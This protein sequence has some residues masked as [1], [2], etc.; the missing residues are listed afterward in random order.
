MPEP[1]EL[2]DEAALRRGT[3]LLHRQPGTLGLRSDLAQ[4]LRQVRHAPA[5]AAIFTA[6]IALG[7]GASLTIFMVIDHVFVQP[8]DVPDAS[9]LV[10][11]QRV[12][13]SAMLGVDTYSSD[14]WTREGYQ[15]MSS[16]STVTLAASDASDPLPVDF[17]GSTLQPRAMFITA[18]YLDLLGVTPA[19]GRA[20]LPSED[21]EGAPVTAI[22]GHAVWQTH[23][24]G[25]PA[26]LGRVIRVNGSP[27][28]VVGIAPR[29]FRGTTL[30]TR[31]PDLLLPF[32]ARAQLTPESVHLP[33]LRIVG[34]L[35]PGATI[36][37]ASAE[38]MTIVESGWPRT[39]PT[40]PPRARARP[41]RDALV[42]PDVQADLRWF[43]TLLTVAVGLTVAIGCTNLT[44]LLL[45]RVDT[46]RAEFALRSVLGATRG[47]LARQ[48]AVETAVL[49]F[50]GG[51][52]ALVV[53]RLIVHGLS[54]FALPG[55]VALS[56][57]GDG[58]VGRTL[59]VAAVLTL[60]VAS[61]VGLVPMLRATRHGLI[62]GVRELRDGAARR[63]THVLVGLQVA[64]CVVL[65]FGA[66]LFVRS[67]SAML[68]ADVGFDPRGLVSASIAMP[69]STTR[70]RGPLIDALVARLRE[71][72]DVVAVAVG[73][74]PLAQGSNMSTAIIE[75]DGVPVEIST[76]LEVAFPGPGYFAT[77][78][79]PIVAGRD[80][81]EDDAARVDGV[82][83]VNES[84]ARALWGA[85]DP[86]AR[87]IGYNQFA[88][89]SNDV[90]TVIGV[91]RDAMVKGIGDRRPVL[92]VLRSSR[93]GR[94]DF[95]ASTMSNALF[96]T[97][98]TRGEPAMLAKPLRRAAADLG[99]PVI[100]V[101]PI[102]TV[103]DELV[104]PQ[105]LG[106]ALLTGLGGVA[107]VVTL[108]GIYG[109]VSGGVSRR[110]RDA[111]IRLALGASRVG[112]AAS[113]MKPMLVVVMLG[114][115]LGA[116]AAW[117]SGR[118]VDRFLYGVDSSDPGTLAL[119]L[120][121]I[122]TIA[123]AAAA[124][125]TVR[126]FRIDPAEALRVDH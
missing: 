22:L 63:T 18:D 108:V 111:G 83:I 109:S 48:L 84:A 37:Q 47:R 46:R 55:G 11:L 40:D 90:Y 12:A 92:Y 112:V 106:R 20:F 72:P 98:R 58:R 35:A 7:L 23:F 16:A 100:S 66:G 91:V 104:K 26:V 67:L 56:T 81:S 61:T 119:V 120:L 93:P 45:A 14:T 73:P 24:G 49:A 1:Q 64:I 41:L 78:G 121:L 29:T 52:G 110:S 94:V 117:G 28:E 53:A 50:A 30:D 97:A 19:L 88:A 17:G 39:R 79:Q 5:F 51:I 75:I 2:A 42:L 6:T 115:V 10:V 95:W 126:I 65:V 54:A 96:L 60:M 71:R 27:A 80:F 89:V 124:I 15:K 123:A 122:S 101:T 76:P 36:E 86:L 25:D 70:Q 103:V 57:L 99:L 9:R 114:L 44:T 38:I 69:W 4:A 74:M 87:Q 85:G 8:L 116:V 68:S 102:E 118:F 82:A 34:R 43:L 32:A 113:T 105:R 59:G 21:Q 62:G 33:R 3:R 77:L 107:L 13:P 125:P 31:A